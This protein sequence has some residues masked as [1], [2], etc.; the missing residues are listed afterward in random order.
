[1]PKNPYYEDIRSYEDV[2]YN[3][4]LPTYSNLA[5][6]IKLKIVRKKKH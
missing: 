4:R 5:K 3:F 2:Y 1:M 6:K